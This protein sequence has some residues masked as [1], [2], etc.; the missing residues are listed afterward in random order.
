M[1]CVNTVGAWTVSCYDRKDKFGSLPPPEP[2][3]YFA[4]SSLVYCWTTQGV[5]RFVCDTLG[6]Y[7][8]VVLLMEYGEKRYCP[9]IGAFQQYSVRADIQHGVKCIRLC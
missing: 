4:T 2:E 1:G 6:V 9:F 5:Q 7:A 8:A 3:H